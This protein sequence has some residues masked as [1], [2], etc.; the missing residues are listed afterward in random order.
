MKF[1]GIVLRL[2]FLF[3]FAF[4]LFFGGTKYTF[5]YIIFDQSPVDETFNAAILN[6]PQFV[7]FGCT[8]EL[9]C[10]VSG[11]T[12]YDVGVWIKKVGNPAAIRLQVAN[13]WNDPTGG[14]SIFS[15][16]ISVSSIS[17][18]TYNLVWFHFPLGVIIG[19]QSSYS[20][21]FQFQFT[22]AN[23]TY[24]AVD[25]YRVLQRD[26][27]YSAPQQWCKTGSGCASSDF[28]WQMDNGIVDTPIP[29]EQIG[30]PNNLPVTISPAGD[31]S[32]VAI[33]C[34]IGR[35]YTTT[36]VHRDG[37]IV[38]HG[39]GV[40][41]R[42][43]CTNGTLSF[44]GF[45]INS[46]LTTGV[47]PEWWRFVHTPLEYIIKDTMGLYFSECDRNVCTLINLVRD[48]NTYDPDI[49]LASSTYWTTVGKGP[50]FDSTD[51]VTWFDT[52]PT[53][54]PPPPLPICCSSILFLPGFEASRLYK[55]SVTSCTV[56]C[57]DTLWEPNGNSDVEAL[58]MTVL[59]ESVDDSIYTRDVLDEAY[60]VLNIYKSFLEKMQDMKSDGDIT[61]F[62]AVPYDWRLPLSD[63]L[64]SG[65]KIDANN[66]SYLAAT[67]SPYILQELRRLVSSSQNGK[68]TIVAHSNGGLL[69]KALLKKLADENDPLIGKVDTLI[70]VAVPQL[71]TPSAVTSLLHGYDQGIPTTMGPFLSSRTARTFGHNVSSAYNFLPSDEYFDQVDTPI[72]TFDA[73]MTDWISR[74][75]A[76]VNSEN[77]L[78][79]FL[80]DSFGRVTSDS[81]DT[82]TPT[83]LI[84]SLLSSAETQHTILDNWT[85]PAGMEVIDI[86]GWG[87]PTTISGLKY[88][89]H[90][91]EI[92]L[93]P[94]WTI[95]GD[96]TVVTPSALWTNGNASTTR[97]WVDEGKYNKDN[98]VQT[99]FGLNPLDHPDIL[100]IPE[101]IT[102]I[103]TNITTSSITTLPTYI[104]TS[105]PTR[106][107]G[108][109]DTRLIYSL[110][111]PLTLDIYDNLG[112]HTG[113]S[114]TTGQIEE[115]IPG[116]YFI[117]F[118]DV[119]YIFTDTGSPMTITMSGYDTGTF[120]FAIEQV[121]GDSI[122]STVTFADIPTTPTTKVNMTIGNNINTLS[123]L[124]VD[125]DNNGTSDIT[126]TP[127]ID[128]VVTY[129]PPPTPATPLPESPVSTGGG[130]GPIMQNTPILI[131]T[132]TIELAST[133]P[134][135][136]IQKQE[137]SPTL[138]V[139]GV[140]TSSPSVARSIVTRKKLPA[141][142]RIENSAQTAQVISSNPQ[143]IS[144]FTNL[145]RKTV[146]WFIAIFKRN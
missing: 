71:G 81:S 103:S 43:Y 136:S 145:W 46:L 62:S 57:E 112:N 73:S 1:S 49:Y 7:S 69:A 44:D 30:D 114:T 82:K 143:L 115:Q 74:Y 122:V 51:H 13:T 32:S 59:G 104:S 61:D 127:V 63:I 93:E 12:V 72:V 37:N 77:G 130:N 4:L 20:Q 133:T 45:N 66:I 22:N 123:P 42:K 53:T 70:L 105:T 23:G 50:I 34:T 3:S 55:T 96:G 95:D 65:K 146:S 75:G 10:K 24:N 113:I 99:G 106:Q 124:N 2:G 60:S 78:D 67:S 41:A 128:D 27:D 48:Y 15:D 98:S 40:V 90:K 25:Y 111:S 28:F 110:H 118:G 56:N 76:V 102:F 87:I 100:E 26:N 9:N 91:G 5:A 83:S 137:R 121:Q 31:V 19:N 16:S 80:T 94:T 140:A 138:G 14:T 79:T 38:S 116:T 86:A 21:F 54:P 101:L 97:Y 125:S 29:Q 144:R 120:T 6:T 88:S 89:L 35:N 68:V 139:G 108:I 129:T 52:R 117:Q 85:P 142:T 36:L 17:D 33:N 8:A 58:F 126:L 131:S 119:K 47:D 132:T 135:I 141:L 107:I 109:N 11:Q 92:K 84:S 64:E 39:Y 18:T 134:T